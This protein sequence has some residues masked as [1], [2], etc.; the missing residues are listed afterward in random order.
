MDYTIK[1]P[2][3]GGQITRT[4]YVGRFHKTTESEV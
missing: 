2:S 1:T 4:A 3:R